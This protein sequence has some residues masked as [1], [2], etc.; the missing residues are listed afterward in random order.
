MYFYLVYNKLIW[1]FNW[2]FTAAY[3]PGR[4]DIECFHRWQ[5]VSNHDLVKRSWT[6]EVLF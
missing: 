5:K 4:T 2:S 1:L 3:F 6:K